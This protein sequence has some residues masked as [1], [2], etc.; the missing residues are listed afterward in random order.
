MVVKN[1]INFITIA[2]ERDNSRK[3]SFYEYLI[4]TRQRYNKS[5]KEIEKILEFVSDL[6]KID[7]Y[8]NDKMDF[9]FDAHHNTLSSDIFSII[10]LFL[11]NQKIQMNIILRHFIETITY[12][13]FADIIS[14]FKGSFFPLFY[15]EWKPYRQQYKL[16]WKGNKFRSGLIK[17]LDEIKVINNNNNNKMESDNFYK[18]YFLHSNYNDIDILFSLP[19]CKKCYDKKSIKEKKSHFS[20]IKT[21][22]ENIHDARFRTHILEICSFCSS[23]G[24]THYTYGIPDFEL[25]CRILKYRLS[26]LTDNITKLDHFYSILSEEFVHFG[27][28]KY[29]NNQ[30]MIIQV[31]GIG[32]IDFY[33]LKTI[34]FILDIL[35]PIL[36]FYLNK[37]KKISK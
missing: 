12:C 7:K 8:A 14:N 9:I 18:F 31:S 32:V 36:K 21:L 26:H 11:T 30:S 24:T 15:S 2:H 34:C 13:L 22:K 1:P 28:D 4:I 23:N 6:D 25:M 16:S 17:R 37:L 33:K 3:N 5:W 29:V 35:T 27:T 10:L 19:I 20:T